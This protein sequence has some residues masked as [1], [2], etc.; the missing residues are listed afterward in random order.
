MGGVLSDY[1]RKALEGPNYRALS[2]EDVAA[3][4]KRQGASLG[5]LMADKSKM[6]ALAHSLRCGALLVGQVQKEGENLRLSLLKFD[7]LTGARVASAEQVAQADDVKGLMTAVDKM[8]SSLQLG[9][10]A[11]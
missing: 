11:P 5:E 8:L 7:R 2:A 4:L 1:L 9:H 3:A 6:V 10:L